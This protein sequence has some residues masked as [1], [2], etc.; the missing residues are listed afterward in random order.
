MVLLDPSPT[1]NLHPVTVQ[2][3]ESA[4]DDCYLP[5][6]WHVKP[7]MMYTDDT[8]VASSNVTC[9]H[10]FLAWEISGRKLGTL[11]S[12][13]HARVIL[14]NFETLDPQVMGQHSVCDIYLCLAPSW[15]RRDTNVNFVIKFSVMEK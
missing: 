14:P 3:Q 8:R 1:P 13:R 5:Y 11:T 9:H 4:P 6:I 2:V 7:V 10:R 15:I 12:Y